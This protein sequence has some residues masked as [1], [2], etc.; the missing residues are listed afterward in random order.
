MGPQSS[1]MTPQGGTKARSGS[2]GARDSPAAFPALT[3]GVGRYAVCMYTYLPNRVCACV[4]ACHTPVALPG[5]PLDFKTF[6]VMNPVLTNGG[7]YLHYY[8]KQLMLLT[9]QARTQV[10]HG[11]VLPRAALQ[12]RGPRHARRKQQRRRC[13]CGRVQLCAVHGSMLHDDST[14]GCTALSSR[15]C[16]IGLPVCPHVARIRPACAGG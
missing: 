9:P 6:L 11:H 16:R 12:A 3:A 8:S 13:W 5:V 7:L 10:G 15:Y 2:I 14:S 4:R 1:V